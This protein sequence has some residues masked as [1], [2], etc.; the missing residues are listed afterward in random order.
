MPAS[1][2]ATSRTLAGLACICPYNSALGMASSTE[3]RCTVRCHS[4][5]SAGTRAAVRSAW[6]RARS[7]SA[8]GLLPAAYNCSLNCKVSAWLWALWRT[9]SRR[10][11]RPRAWA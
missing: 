4:R 3:S 6:A 7:R 9:I 5:R 1:C 11:S 2:K 10:C 8:S